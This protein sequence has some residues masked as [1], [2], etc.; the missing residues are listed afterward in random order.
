MNPPWKKHWQKKLLCYD[1]DFFQES[2]HQEGFFYEDYV[3][4]IVLYEGFSPDA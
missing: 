2:F 3:R 1:S 4:G